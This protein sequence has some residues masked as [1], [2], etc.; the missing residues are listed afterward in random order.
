MSF[1]SSDVNSSHTYIWE[2]NLSDTLR[3]IALLISSKE[4]PLSKEHLSAIAHKLGMSI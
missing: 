1:R 2:L 3:L 4:Q